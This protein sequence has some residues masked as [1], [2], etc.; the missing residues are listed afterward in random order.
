MFI[1]V[2]E[3]TGSSSPQSFKFFC[4][5]EFKGRNFG[6]LASYSFT[7]VYVTDIYVKEIA[8]VLPCARY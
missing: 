3:I 6:K 4:W 2:L 7:F 5:T 8:Q 1:N